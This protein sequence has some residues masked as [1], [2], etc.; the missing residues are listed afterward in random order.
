MSMGIDLSFSL[1]ACQEIDLWGLREVV[2]TWS[3]STMDCS[4][5]EHSTAKGKRR[6]TGQSDE[7]VCEREPEI[8]N[9]KKKIAV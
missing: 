8:G 1:V 2:E 6:S 9:H 3:S 5:S 7:G 4:V